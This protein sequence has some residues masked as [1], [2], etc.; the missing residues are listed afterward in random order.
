LGG[1]PV[2]KLDLWQF[3]GP[4]EFQE[5]LSTLL[6][7]EYRGFRSLDV[8]SPDRGVDGYIDNYETIFQF[9]YPV[10]QRLD[11]RSVLNSLEI[12]LKSFANRM[13]YWRLVSPAEPSPGIVEAVESKQRETGIDC[14]IWG[15]SWILA[16]LAK[17]REIAV[18]T[19]GADV[20]E[21]LD[22]MDGVISPKLD[23]IAKQMRSRRLIVVKNV[24]APPADSISTEEATLVFEKVKAIAEAHGGGKREFGRAWSSFYNKFGIPKGLYRQISKRRLPEILK[25]LDHCIVYRTQI[26]S[27][28]K[29]DSSLRRGIKSIVR[30][31]RWTKSQEEMFYYDIVGLRHV[32]EMTTAQKELV[33]AKLNQL[34]TRPRFRLVE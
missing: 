33:L 12:A 9:K 24:V 15:K 6:H 16:L 14:R 26:A 22:R 17:H 30:Q 1:F 4:Q 10:R 27:P 28:E 21:V 18:Q 23:D 2:K 7:A 29:R 25:W 8:W 32:T 31:L 11:K 34:Q 3:S 19:F 13:R 5:F 20:Q